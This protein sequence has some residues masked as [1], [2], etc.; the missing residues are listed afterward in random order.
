MI[1]TWQSPKAT[2]LPQELE[3]RAMDGSGSQRGAE[4]E[5]L[6]GLES[7]CQQTQ[8]LCRLRLGEREK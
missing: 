8:A 4:G 7:E 6:P 5:A 3:K 1:D 2:F